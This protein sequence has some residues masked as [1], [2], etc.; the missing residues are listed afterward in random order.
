MQFIKVSVCCVS[1]VRSILPSLF[2]LRRWFLLRLMMQADPSSKTRANNM[3]PTPPRTPASNDS[4]TNSRSRE[5]D[6]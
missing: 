6:G 5:V 4:G 2:F 3:K 1:G